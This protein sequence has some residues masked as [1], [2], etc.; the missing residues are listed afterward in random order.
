MCLPLITAWASTASR[1]LAELDK[2]AGREV[3]SD[4]ISARSMPV[5]TGWS[6]KS[7]PVRRHVRYRKLTMASLLVEIGITPK[8]VRAASGPG[9]IGHTKSSVSVRMSHRT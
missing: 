2:P 1:L 8:R 4:V 3:P 5:F 7:M 9:T 6:S